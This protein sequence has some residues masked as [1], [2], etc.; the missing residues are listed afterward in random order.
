[1]LVVD[2]EDTF[3]AML[4]HV[5]RTL[6]L[7]VELRSYDDVTSRRVRAAELVV[8]GP[9]PGDPRDTAH[10]KIRLMGA[11]LRTR[12]D[13]GGPLLAV[14]LGHQLLA[15]ELG[16]ELVRKP[17][18]YQGKQVE[19]D[20]FGRPERVGFYNAFAA[21]RPAGGVA[22]VEFAADPESGQVHALRSSRMRLAGVQF[23]PESVLTHNG[24]GIVRELL[25]GL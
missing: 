10:R 19:I 4:A 23:H 5:L 22:N 3:T 17:R 24:L 15:H 8:L 21:V 2:G 9:G 18:P 7:H 14:C 20:L 6:G 13:A 12:L 16:L 1:M 25:A 11:L